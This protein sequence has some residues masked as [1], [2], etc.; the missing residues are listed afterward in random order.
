MPSE[1]GVIIVDSGSRDLFYFGQLHTLC[2]CVLPATPTCADGAI[3]PV[4]LF[5]I[6]TITFVAE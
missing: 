2:V 3:T 6:E 5:V 4:Y 1:V